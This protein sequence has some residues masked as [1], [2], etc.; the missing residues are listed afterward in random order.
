MSRAARE[1]APRIE[2]LTFAST[3]QPGGDFHDV[4]RI[5]AWLSSV[6]VVHAHRGKEHWLA[7]VANRLTRT[8]R[9]LVRTRHI[10]RPVSTHAGNRWLYRRAT[11]RVIT[12]TETIRRQYIV[13]GLLGPERIVTLAGGVNTEAY[14]PDVPAAGLRAR[15]GIPAGAV[16]IGLV[17]GLRSMKGHRVVLDALGR[18]R[19]VGQCPLVVFIGSGPLDAALREAVRDAALEPQVTFLGF[20]EDLPAAIAALDIALYVPIESEGMSRVLFEYLAAGR[21]II[22]S[23][24]GVVPEVV[25][26]GEAALLVSGGDAAALAGALAR[27]LAA[28]ALRT[29]LAAS[30]R[31]LAETRYSSRVVAGQLAEVYRSVTER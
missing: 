25:V 9:P 18:L 10:V 28:P 7:A 1:G 29:R 21:A 16:L 24:V 20:T 12:V 17:G 4:R 8:P 31:R 15:L 22:A 23:R 19:E 27:L 26:D 14:R 5:A 11:A 3:L 2:T 13:S 6:D 30:A